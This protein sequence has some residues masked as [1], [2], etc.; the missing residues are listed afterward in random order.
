M[1]DV[2]GQRSERKKWI[3]CFDEAKAVIFIAALSDY[4]LYLSEDPTQNRMLESLKLFSTICNN[5]WFTGASMIL[6]LNKCDL[7]ELKLKKKSSSI[8][9]CF[10]NFSGDPYSYEQATAYIQVLFKSFQISR[11]FEECSPKQYRLVHKKGDSFGRL[12]L[13]VQSCHKKLTFKA[14]KL[15]FQAF[16]RVT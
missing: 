2:G 15:R 11:T 7:F 12:Y 8:T 1:L 4:D 5:R 6:F 3:H 16:K 10:P 9:L 13:W 14:G